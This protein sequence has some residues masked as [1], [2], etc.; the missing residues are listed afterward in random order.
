M[1]CLST[2]RPWTSLWLSSKRSRPTCPTGSRTWRSGWS[3][4]EQIYSNMQPPPPSILCF[5]PSVVTQTCH[6]LLLLYAFVYV[7]ICSSVVYCSLYASISDN[8]FILKIWLVFIFTMK[9]KECLGPVLQFLISNFLSWE[10][11]EYI[12]GVLLPLSRMSRMQW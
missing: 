2:T 5:T 3:G 10:Q 11:Y 7:N 9:G 12:Y 4:P 6:L 8:I 1:W